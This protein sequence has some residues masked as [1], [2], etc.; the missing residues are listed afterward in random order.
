MVVIRLSRS[1]SKKRPFYHLSVAD[2]RNPRDGRFIERV[3]FF[4]PVAR[5]S[6]EAL[7]VDAERVAY[8]ISKGAQPSARVAKLLKDN[9]KA[10]A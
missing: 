6:E 9:A 1:G 8:W 3:G 4:N 7:R 10:Q 5:G 2:E